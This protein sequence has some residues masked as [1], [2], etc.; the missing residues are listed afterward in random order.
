[1]DLSPTRPPLTDETPVLRSTMTSMIATLRQG[2]TLHLPA[3]GVLLQH[4][5]P[6][7]L[8]TA[9]EYVYLSVA[10]S[11]R[12]ELQPPPKLIQLA[13][14]RQHRYAA[15]WQLDEL[16]EQGWRIRPL[17][18]A[19][20]AADRVLV[21]RN[22]GLGD[23]LR[24]T[25]ALQA[26]HQQWQVEVEVATYA[27]YVPLL[28]GLPGIAATHALGTN[29]RVERFDAIVDLNWAVESGEEA[30]MRPRQD[31]FAKLLHVRLNRRAPIYQ[32]ASSERRWARQQL[33]RWHPP[34]IGIQVHASCR[35]RTYPAARIATLTEMLQAAGYT[36]AFLG[37]RWQYSTPPQV[38]DLTG[39]L[40]LRQA[41]ALIEQMSVM[42]CPDSGLL[43]LA[44]AVG[45]PTVGLFGPIPPELRTVGYPH[46]Q[47][48]TVS[49]ACP[50]QPC[51]DSGAAGCRKPHCMHAIEPQS[52][53]DAVHA[54]QVDRIQH[55]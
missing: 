36:V 7:R 44:V 53:L 18:E 49:G 48:V 8:A 17:E 55:T 54:V 50:H 3:S 39:Y 21:I 15:P 35:Q 24:L 52:V 4:R 9:A 12:V 19:L 16:A 43:H 29:Y 26:M 51:F 10:H 45:T 38:V 13:R 46:C 30:Q 6:R 1:M 28:R 40:S 47:A 41:A 20:D 2:R 5:Q 27:R 37:E 33:A 32:V 25:P 22:M 34:I 23:V 42:I 31:L 11:H 14:D